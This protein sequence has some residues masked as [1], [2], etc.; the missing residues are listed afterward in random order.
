MQIVEEM[1]GMRLSDY[2]NIPFEVLREYKKFDINNL[3]LLRE[4]KF[5]QYTKSLEKLELL[6]NQKDKIIN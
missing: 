5:R 2:S 4:R 3:K 6:S 1:K